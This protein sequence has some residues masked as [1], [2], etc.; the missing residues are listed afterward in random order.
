MKKLQPEDKVKMTPLVELIPVDFVPKKRGDTL[1]V[2]KVLRKKVEE[3]NKY[4]GHAP[5]F[6]DLWYLDQFNPTPLSSKGTHPLEFLDREL[7]SNQLTFLPSR[8][9]FIPVTGLNRSAD[10]Q[11]C[12]RNYSKSRSSRRVHSPLS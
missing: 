5:L 11:F 9:S 1:D 7:H 10:Y 12:G 4:W 2:D 6:L 3:L 8:A